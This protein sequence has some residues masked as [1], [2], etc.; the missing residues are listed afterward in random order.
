MLTGL[1]RS[2]T[3]AILT[4]GGV[5]IDGKPVLKPSAPLQE[6]QHLVAVLPAPTSGTVDARRVGRNCVVLDDE[7]FAV[8]I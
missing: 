5:S 1:S 8:I 7:D 2:E 4:S 6:G 3:H